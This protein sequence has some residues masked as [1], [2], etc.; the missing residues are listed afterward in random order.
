[1]GEWLY[2]FADFKEVIDRQACDVLV[3][4][5]PRVG[6]FTGWNKWRPYAGQ[7]GVRVANHLVSEISLHA[8]LAT[9]TAWLVE[10]SPSAA[11]LFPHMPIPDAHGELTAPQAPGLGLAFNEGNPETRPVRR[12]E[13][14]ARPRRFLTPPAAVAHIGVREPTRVNAHHERT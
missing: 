3:V 14:R 6:G 9:P 13:T 11:A 5:L 8:M 12:M 7:R 2:T 10:Y 1:M 4:D